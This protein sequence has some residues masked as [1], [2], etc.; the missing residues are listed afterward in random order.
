MRPGILP[1]C[2]TIALA[3]GSFATASQP[4]V[5]FV[6]PDPEQG[7]SAAVVV[8]AETALVYSTQVVGPESPDQETTPDQVV[9]EVLDRLDAMLQAGGSGLDRAVRLHVVLAN[10]DLLPLL[11]THLAER[12]ADH[13]PPALTVVEGTLPRSGAWIAVD[14]VATTDAQPSAGQVAWPEVPQGQATGQIAG[15][16]LAV[17]PSGPRVFIAGQAEPADDLATAT[18][19]TLDSL[20]ETLDHLGLGTDQVVQLKAFYLPPESA[21]VVER[22]VAAFFQGKE[23]PPLVLVEWESTLPIEIELVATAPKPGSD[24]VIDYLATPALPASPVYSR[25]ARVNRGD[26]V[27]LS[28]LFGP[29]GESGAAQ[30]EGIFD[31]MIAVLGAS[32]SDL[33]HLAK[34]TYYVSA[35]DSSQALNDLRPNYYDPKR[36]PAAS[37]AQVPGVGL[38]RRSITVDMI[39]VVPE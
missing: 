22:E 14:A 31:Q 1:V 19:K 32:G 38:A 21:E 24:Q 16:P 4:T 3:I 34:A 37:K 39:A 35:N 18:R 29:E 17:L 6:Q 11:K 15:A 25:V 23:T 8:P 36:P 12:L 13:D 7:T 26:L 9:G 2:A 28:G 27:F 5:R 33:N 30:V 20:A 10:A